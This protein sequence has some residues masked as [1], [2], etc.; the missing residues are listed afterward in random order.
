M[1]NMIRI[2]I[3][4]LCAVL[5]LTAFLPVRLL[6]Q[7]DVG[8]IS[9]FIKDQSG[10][11]VPNAMVTVFDESTGETHIATSDSQGH[12]TITNLRPG[13]YSMTTEAKNFKKFTSVHNKLDASTTLSL[14]ADLS[15]GATTET[16]EVTA[17]ASVLRNRV[18]IGTEPGHRTTD[19]RSATQ[20]TESLVHGFAASG[21]SQRFDARR[22]QLCGRWRRT[23][24]NQRSADTGHPG[25]FRW[26]SRSPHARQR[27]HHRRRQ[28]RRN[29]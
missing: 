16:V 10:A 17:T 20:W 5:S 29:C 28:C 2:K 27:S 1:L 15:I 8:S 24:P 22:L 7:S 14:D 13:T 19:Q 26:R 12:Y 25:D 23:L 4:C 11:V 9:G 21:P 3:W 18:W 6:A